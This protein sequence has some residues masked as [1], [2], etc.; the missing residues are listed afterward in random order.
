MQCFRG[1]CLVRGNYCQVRSSDMI[2]IQVTLSILGELHLP[3]LGGQL[4]GYYAITFL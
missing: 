1:K 2:I 4:L 3:M